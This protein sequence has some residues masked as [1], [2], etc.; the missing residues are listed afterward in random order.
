MNRQPASIPNKTLQSLIFALIIF[1]STNASTQTIPKAPPGMVYV[2][3]GYF[4]MGDSSSEAEDAKPMHFVYT[5]AFFIDQYEVSNLEYQNF[6][7]AT[8]HPPPLYWE[9][10]HFNKPDH[11]VVGVSW[12]DAMAFARWKGRRLPTEAEWEKAARGNDARLYPWGEKWSKGFVLHFVNV[13]GMEDQYEFT[14]PVNYYPSGSSPFGVISMAGNVWEWCLDWYDKDY[15]R[16][17]PEL[18][19][20]GPPP[21][22][23]KK[24]KVLRGGSWVNSIDGVQVIQRSRN[25]PTSKKT[26][27]GFRTALPAP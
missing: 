7:E 15:Y 26:I 14:A 12:F 22:A 10:E 6:M 27:Y 21:A 9:D 17:S 19:P 23:E 20:E 2:P 18:N 3:E 24:M 8:Q 25:L 1:Y 4:Q 11:P 5:S 13:F 16:I